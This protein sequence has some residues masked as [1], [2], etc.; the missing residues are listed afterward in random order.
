MVV[1]TRLQE[2]YFNST[3]VLKQCKKSLNSLN[4]SEGP[5][6]WRF[7]LS[8]PW[9]DDFNY[10]LARSVIIQS[11]VSMFAQQFHLEL[12]SDVL[13]IHTQIQ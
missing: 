10:K 12:A 7:Y 6:S 1:W 11:Q 4:H 9:T 8:C 5:R 13:F 3:F 2:K